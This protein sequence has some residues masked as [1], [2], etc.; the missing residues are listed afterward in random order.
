[1][2]KIFPNDKILTQS[3]SYDEI[4]KL[5]NEEIEKIEN[6]TFQSLSE[7]DNKLNLPSGTTYEMSGFADYFNFKD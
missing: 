2:K 6:P 5:V 4:A 1:M 7:I 3:K